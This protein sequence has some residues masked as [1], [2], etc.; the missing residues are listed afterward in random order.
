MSD[1]LFI[2]EINAKDVE[3]NQHVAMMAALSASREP[4]VPLVASFD[5]YEEL[6]AVSGNRILL[7]GHGTQALTRAG[8]ATRDIERIAK[9]RPDFAQEPM[10]IGTGLNPKLAMSN[11]ARHMN[12]Q[13]IQ[14]PEKAKTLQTRHSEVEL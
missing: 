5:G 12:G 6:E 14:M 4:R 8:F 7:K 11:L 10:A 2:S 3:S 13:D 9:E 1:K